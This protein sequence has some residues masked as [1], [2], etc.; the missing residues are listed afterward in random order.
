MASKALLVVLGLVVTVSMGVGV[1][2]GMTIADG[3]PGDGTDAT[4][5]PTATPVPTAGPGGGGGTDGGN[6]GNAVTPVPPSSYDRAQIEAAVVAAVNEYR[7]ENG[8]STLLTEGRTAERVQEMSR[9]HSMI[10]AS[11]ERVSHTIDGTDSEDRYRDAELFTA[12]K[13][14]SNS[15]KYIVDA[16]NNDLELVRKVPAGQVTDGTVE[17]RNEQQVA[18]AIVNQWMDEP[19]FAEKLS[20]E[21]AERIAVGVL[22]TDDGEA[23]ATLNIC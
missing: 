6:A 4:A 5:G 23:F 11:V 14:K 22:V 15:G 17:N 21:N 10:M 18:Q 1:V 16:Q 12:C 2:I 3:G 19:F 9:N 20:Y 13:F 7:R 8:L